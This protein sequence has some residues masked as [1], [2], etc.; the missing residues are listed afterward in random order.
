LAIRAKVHLAQQDRAGAEA[1]L[2]KSIELDPKL[3]GSHL[4]LAQLYIATNR[5]QQAVDNL[6]QYTKDNTSVAALM[7]LAQ[8]EQGLKHFPQA[9]EAYEKVVNAA[10]NAALALNNLAVLYAEQF[11]QID[12]AYDLAKRAKDA[13][14]GEAHIGD[15]LGWI[16]FKKGDY[17]N[18]LPLLKESAAK[19]PDSTE[20]QYHL[21]LTHYM[22]GNEDSARTALEKAV[23]GPAAFPQKEEAQQ[24]LAILS[25]DTQRP[26]E[27]AR[28]NLESFLKKQPKDPAALTRLGRLEARD[29]SPD[30]AI[31]SYRK[32]VDADPLFAPAL[33]DLTL[34]YA[35]RTND[36]SKALE[37]GAKARQAYPDDPELAKT[38]GILN[39]RRGLYPQSVELLNQAAGSRRDDAEIELYLGK[40]YQELK[41]WDECKPALERALA[42]NLAAALREDAQARLATCSEQ[43]AQ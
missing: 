11:G 41:K 15:T 28:T 36:E 31:D 8:I 42:L 29:G 23:Q 38:L 4:L 5:A 33:R 27:D 1:D 32:A 2:V 14:P 20:I 10:P 21:G 37:M 25:M 6:Q 7:E 3:E 17:R 39:F 9:R 12:K 40:S 43:A 24:R 34:L 26:A 18:A 22:L 16:T 30:Q 19:L 35:G 13:A